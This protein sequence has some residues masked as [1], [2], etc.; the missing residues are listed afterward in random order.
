MTGN[1]PEDTVFPSGP[2]LLT[3]LIDLHRKTDDED[4]VEL[5]E[6]EIITE[7]LGCLSMLDPDEKPAP[8]ASV[9]TL[10]D[11]HDRF[12]RRNKE[13]GRYIRL[14]IFEELDAFEGFH[15]NHDDDP[16]YVFSE[17]SDEELC[18]LQSIDDPEIQMLIDHELTER[19]LRQ[20]EE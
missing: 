17:L 1:S 19:G 6:T 20:S 10:I 8:E 3:A 16:F 14:R 7:G 2:A 18:Y 13:V 15:S 12:V 11:C 5:I 9:E 4:V